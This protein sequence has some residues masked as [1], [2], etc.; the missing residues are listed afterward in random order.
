MRIQ[1]KW[2]TINGAERL[3]VCDLDNDT[4]A[5][6]LRRI[7][8]TGVKVGCGTGVCGS[9]SVLLDGKVVRSC[10]RKMDKVPEYS[11]ITTIEGIGSPN[12]LHPLQQA[13][14]TYGGVQ[15]G[16]CSPGFI[17]SAY[18]LLQEN[19]NPSRQEVRDW[20]KKHR[21]ICRCTGYKPLVDAVMAAAEV[22]RGDK[23]MADISYHSPA[24]AQ[25]YGTALPRPAALAK[26]CGLC[27]YG[28]DI[29]LKMPAGTLHAAVVQPR[30]AHHARILAVNI[31]EAQAAAGVYKVITA[32]DVQGSNLLPTFA[33]HAR[34]RMVDAKQPVL[35]SE[36]IMRYGDVVAL[37]VADSPQHARAAAALVTLEFEQLPEYTNLLDAVAPGASNIQEQTPNWY[38]EQPVLK[39]CA[40]DVPDIIHKS[41]YSVSGSFYSQREPHLSL[42]GDVVQA[43]WAADGMLNIQCKSQAVTA[44]R[45]SVAA[46]VGVPADKI[47]IILNPV[48]GSFGWAMA[49]NS[50][51]LAA[52]AAIA[53]DCPVSLQFSYE[54]FMHFSGKRA[55]AYS[56]GSIACDEDGRITALQY[57]LALDVGPYTVGGEMILQRIALYF[58]WPYRIPNI[59]GLGR[60]VL[61]NHAFE[62]AYRGFGSP[63]VF[64]A[65]EA[66][67]D[68][69]ACEA[70]IDPLEFR[71]LNVGR[72]GDTGSTSWPY[73]EISSA[74]L[75]EWMRPKYQAALAEA[76]QADTPEKR[77][78]VGVAIGGY[79][80]SC[81]DMDSAG[82]KLELNPDGSV[83]VYNTWED[84]GQGGDVGTLMFVVEALKPLGITPEMVHVR[85]NDTG[86][87]PDSGPAAGS[88]SH[89]MNGMGTLKVAHQMLDT[90]RKDD[91][92]YRSYQELQDE[93][94]PC[95][96]AATHVNAEF[97]EEY[98]F[99]SPDTGEGDPIPTYMYGMNMAEVEVDV[100]T[101]KVTVLRFTHIADVGN[102]GNIVS[103][104]GQGYGGISHSI[105]FALSEDYDDVHKHTNMLSAGVPDVS[106]IPDEIDLNFYDHPRKNTPYGSSGCSEMYQSGTHMAVINGIFNACGVRIYELPATPAKIKAGL[107]TLARGESLAV[108]EPYY[109]GSDFLDTMADIIANPIGNMEPENADVPDA[110]KIV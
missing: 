84:M 71:Y 107:E 75:I 38:V 77:R 14:I 109:L 54:E 25:Y 31:D 21:N 44:A 42:E 39:G 46:A 60:S 85:I 16:F 95:Q 61:T 40:E 11:T 10:T 19:N 81:G 103:V 64:T 69:L 24:N 34:S 43:Y 7:G 63:Q 91:G 17:V 59:L 3:V 12:N 22:L 104:Q 73:R 55:P 33:M 80:C 94:L 76:R 57:D 45:E 66:L 53:C 58:G 96:W 36:K 27:D 28:D 106:M 5:T 82:C 74:Q 32:S 35:A 23:T 98:P 83:N 68:M 101:G 29:A 65:S 99:L 37:V 8:L 89:M 97:D 47:R 87:C 105:G 49:C 15:C 4:L 72:P 2:L 100:A 51:A 108:P 52:I 56:N 67:I 92:S 1:K 62:V 86:T 48:G 110:L 93:G 78:G 26:V 88:R 13:W 18:A 79:N 9:C 30:V 41:K 90:L 70:G 6:L 50:Y 102:V 20:F